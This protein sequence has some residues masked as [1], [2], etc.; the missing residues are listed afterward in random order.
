MDTDSDEQRPLSE[1]Q[2]EVLILVGV[3]IARYQKIEH[4]L[5]ILVPNIE[6]PSTQHPQAASLDIE[7]LLSAKS[8]LG[9]LAQEFRTSVQTDNQDALEDYLQAIVAHRNELIHHFFRMPIG[10]LKDEEACRRA[11]EHLRSR[12]SYA[13][14]LLQSLKRL[15]NKIVVSWES[16]SLTSQPDAL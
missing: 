8:T 7:S 12:L 11:A 4:M 2:R 5:K 10:K 15:S 16:S 9:M 6:P 14:G 13:D 3:S 1:Y